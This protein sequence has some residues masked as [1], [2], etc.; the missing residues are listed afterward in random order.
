[1]VSLAM[2]DEIPADV[3]MVLG[4]RLRKAA[5][6]LSVPGSLPVLFFGDLPAASIATVGLNPSKQEY[7]DRL[8]GQL[9]GP[10]RRFETLESLGATSRET[11]TDEQINQAFRTM[12]SYFQPGKPV[13][14]WFNHL[15]RVLRPLGVSYSSGSAAHL[16][17]VQEATNPTWSELLKQQPL[18]AETLLRSDL[19]FLQ[20]EIETFS[21]RLLICNGTTA[22]D[23]VVRLLK[24]RVVQSGGLKRIT[25]W[26][27]IA[28]SGP[29][30]LGVAGWNIPLVRATGLGSAGEGQLGELISYAVSRPG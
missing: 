26:V 30:T 19:V 28:S 25:W 17:L 2:K 22:F 16:D 3:A 10:G 23:N 12:R 5:S 24:G 18:E 4:A 1:V 11:L 8:G 15:D 9:E 14:S 27:A 7:L 13:Y 6:P 29:R 21:L 20:W